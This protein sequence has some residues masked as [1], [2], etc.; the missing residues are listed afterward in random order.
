MKLIFQSF[1]LPGII[2]FL[3]WLS[4]FL[5]FSLNLDFGYLGI[6]PR[7][8]SGL[9]GIFFTPLLHG[10]WQH[11][12]S[13]TPTFFVL[14]GMMRFFYP[15]AS[16]RAMFYILLLS[17]TGVWIFARHSYHIGASGLI[18]GFAF[19]LFFGAVFRKDTRS[20][21]ISL[22]VLLFYGSMVWGLLPLDYS[23]SYEAHIFGALSGTLMA[24]IDRK[25]DIDKNYEVGETNI[26]ENYLP[27]YKEL[28]QRTSNQDEA[29]D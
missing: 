23:V 21:A 7:S 4:K 11:L 12:V 19:Y 26:A 8:I 20:L 15:T 22:F 29:D 10:N 25:K 27:T 14:G 17:G 1:L 18:Y 5:E 2:V 9:K 16:L 3:M 24:F 28:N 13:N 6:L